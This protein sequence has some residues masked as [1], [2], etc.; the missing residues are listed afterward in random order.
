[1]IDYRWR[2]LRAS[3]SERFGRFDT[4]ADAVAF[5]HERFEGTGYGCTEVQICADPNRGCPFPE[6]G[7]RGGR[8][9]SRRQSMTGD[10]DLMTGEERAVMAAEGIPEGR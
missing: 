1:M 10:V 5:V 7:I 2:V 9:V 6:Y 8:I 4:L 3:T